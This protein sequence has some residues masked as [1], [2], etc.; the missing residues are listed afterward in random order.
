M[1]PPETQSEFIEQLAKPEVVLNKFFALSLDLL[2][3]Y[4]DDGYFKQLSPAWEEI[5][6]WTLAEFYM[7]PWMKFVHPD[8]VKI[9]ESAQRQCGQQDLVE[10]ENRFRH[11]N[12]SYRWLSWRLSRDEDGLFY[13]VAKD[14]TAAK[15]LEEALGDRSNQN[16]LSA[17]EAVSQTNPSSPQNSVPLSVKVSTKTP[18]KQAGDNPAELPSFTR[19]KVRVEVEEKNLERALLELKEWQTR[20]EAALCQSEEQ[21]H[22]VFNEAPIG[23]MLEGLDARF[24]R[25]NQALCEMLGYTESELMPLTCADITHPEDWKQEIPYA[26]QIRKGAIESYQLE[27]RYI[28]KNH[29]ILW[30]NLTTILLKDKAREIFY[31]LHMVEDITQHKQALEALQH[32]EARYRAIVEDQME[33]ICRFQPDST[34]T[35]VNDAYC[36]YFNKP[37][38]SLI[39]Q[40]FLPAMPPEDRQLIT[41][42]F[43]YLSVEKPINTYEH[44]V[45]LPGGEIR[46]QQWS[47]RAVFDEDGNFI[48]CQAVGRDI[49]QLKQAEADIRKALEKEREL[50]ELRSSFVSLVSHEFRTPLTTIQSSAELLEHYDKKLSD[51]KKL[52]H[53]KRIQTAVR[54]MTQ[55]LEDVL[56]VGQAE[57]DK[58]KFNPVPMNVVTFCRDIV[59]TLQ[60]TAPQEHQL[61]FV[62]QCDRTDAQ[63]DE[64]LLG[65][66]VTNLLSNAIKYS[67]QGGIVQ[68]DLVC[69]PSSVIFRIQD[70]GIGIPEADLEKLFESFGRASNVGTIQGTGLGL[71]IVKRCVDMH[72]GQIAVEST[73]GVGTTFTVTLPL[74]RLQEGM[75][76]EG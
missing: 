13:G 76:D 47:D 42:N 10:Y 27:K 44:R 22:R 72:G 71:A 39:G 38:E 46:W 63:I 2:C 14:I 70:A 57:A 56:I 31:I 37:R 29:E 36:R 35:F 40:K 51:E 5:L 32:S 58:L 52:N 8:D 33:L 16:I 65:H 68:F 12:G 21:F 4:R 15:R 28:N 69:N 11:K 53:F 59:E 73:L 6:G 49:T 48:E 54:R 74:N 30:V 18:H 26:E 55:L 64:K 9:T 24:F 20:Y 60:V 25:V 34:I 41:K 66:I 45:I 43:S 23:I 67:P 50:S 1:K 61:N 3:I 7:Q 75:K 17:K 19:S 62:T